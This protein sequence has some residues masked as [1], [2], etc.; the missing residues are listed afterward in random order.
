ML[1]SGRKKN[2]K[3]LWAWNRGLGDNLQVLSVKS[4]LLAALWTIASIALDDLS[5]CLQLEPGVE[6]LA[7]LGAQDSLRTQICAEAS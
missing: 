3:E 6:E 5:R 4:Q 1:S 7:A 2:A